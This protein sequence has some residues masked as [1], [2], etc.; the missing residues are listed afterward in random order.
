M[1]ERYSLPEMTRIWS[2]QFKLQTWFRIEVLA[3]EGR[4]K[5][6][7]L[8]G[9]IVKAFWAIEPETFDEQRIKQ[10]EAEVNHESVAFQMYIEELVG[11]KCHGIFHRGLT[12]SDVLDTC[13]NYQLKE[14]SDLIIAKLQNLA[15]EFK[16]LALEHKLTPCI[17]RSHGIHG[18]PIT[19][20]LKMLR[21]YAE[22][23][24][25]ISRLEH[26][27]K[28]ISVGMISGA[29]GTYSTINPEVEKHVCK[30]MGLE[31]ESISSQI[32]PRDR[33]AMYFST[34]GVVAASLERVSIELRQLQIT[35]IGEIQEPFSTKQ[36]GS[37]AMP[38]KKNPIKLENVSGLSRLIQTYVSAALGN[39]S[40]WQER[41]MSHSSVERA[42]G[43]DTT[44]TLDF[45]THRLTGILKGLV[46]DRHQMETNLEKL[47]GIAYSHR[48]LNTLT[49]KGVSK[50][51]AYRMVQNS[52][53]MSIEGDNNFRNALLKYK[54]IRNKL[55]HGY[56]YEHELA[57]LFDLEYFQ[58]EID[59][60][61]ERVLGPEKRGTG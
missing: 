20:G 30:Q 24:R 10:I 11:D 54:E 18:E 42:L 12:S 27:K 2:E 60:I 41:D 3:C 16:R 44:I 9:D 28:E 33:H 59:G 22:T 17:G 40:L 14:A 19:F 26:A 37:S 36:K 34:L 35:E 23:Q 1:L 57:D 56:G 61:Y 49:E 43:P 8:D 21:A 5:L 50:D 48:I 55:A 4:T 15:A 7:E 25:N 53:F 52:A 32:I 38:H 47:G 46:V 45:A 6:G 39:V 13:Y 29:M 51:E 31:P 58:K